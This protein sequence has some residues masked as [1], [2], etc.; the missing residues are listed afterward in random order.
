M[1]V[2]HNVA[3]PPCSK[4]GDCEDDDEEAVLVNMY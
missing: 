1:V 3:G 2:L 4:Q